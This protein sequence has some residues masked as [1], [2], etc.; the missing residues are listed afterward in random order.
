MTEIISP[1]RCR[2]FYINGRWVDPARPN[3]YEVIDPA[4]EESVATIS[5]GSATDVDTAVD[6]AA[7]AFTSWRATTV[8]QRLDLLAAL[9]ETYLARSDEIA[10][11]M[12]VEMGTPITFSREVQA[13][14]GDGHI[15]AM[16]EALGNHR[17]ERPS[18]RGGSTLRDEPVGV[19][20]LI[21]PWNWPVNQVVV[22]VAAALAAGCTMVLKPSEESPLSALML[23]EMIDDIGVPD[24]VFNLVNGDG[25]GVG[26]A[27]AG[28]PG[29]DLVSFTGSTRAGVAVTKAA[30]DTVK[31]VSLELGGKSPNLLFAD[32]D[33]DAATTYSVRSCFSNSGQSC[34]APSR[35]LV[36]DS[37]Y[38]RVVEL[39]VGVA[40]RTTVGD[41]RVDG[42]HLGPV[43]NS[44]QYDHIQHLIGTGIDEATLV[45]GGQGRPDGCERGF[46]VRPTIFADVTNDMQIARIEV[47]GP[48]LSI[49]RFADE[50]EAIE[51][52]DDTPYGLSA[53]IQTG[54]TDRARRV[55]RRLRAGQVNINGA[56]ADYDV[57]FGGVKQS[58]TGRENGA[59]G[60]EEYLDVKSITGA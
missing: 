24:G 48:V 8:E 7:S 60:M 26:S 19:C 3:D 13:P 41:P 35:L 42:D 2:R 9:K 37:V 5:L 45:A 46:Y 1:E 36:D 47:F 49:L 25:A 12:T 6:A 15:E 40:E 51:I 22:K 33:I 50:D 43:V 10:Y 28:H 30:A 44:R 56:E 32:A 52:A 21:T 20:G 16:I 38:D 4:T 23:A 53:Y 14:C 58:G 54:D 11:A 17:F 55:A 57:P 59:F 27:I 39:A 18:G 31:R 29:I 34:D